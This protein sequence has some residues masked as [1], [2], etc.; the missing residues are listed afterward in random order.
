MSPHRFRPG[1]LA[2]ALA[3]GSAG[4]A[5]AQPVGQPARGRL[6]PE[7]WQR[8]FPEHKQLTIRGHQAR[9]AILQRGERCVRAAR[10]A[11]ALRSCQLE[12]RQAYQEHRR[13]HKEQMR[14]LFESKGIP[15]PDWGKRGGGRGG[16][17]GSDD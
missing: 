2:L 16:G 7:Q 4:T 11:A 12:E 1:L 13:R 5:L 6:S 9:I 15:V 8:V 14:R 3:L 17:W 10:D